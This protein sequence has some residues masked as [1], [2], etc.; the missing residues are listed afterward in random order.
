MWYI[1]AKE[2]PENRGNSSRLRNWSMIRFKHLWKG[3]N[4]STRNN[5]KKVKEIQNKSVLLFLMCTV[6]HTWRSIWFQ[7]F[8]FYRV[9]KYFSCRHTNRNYYALRGY[10]K[11]GISQTISHW[12]YDSK[13]ITGRNSYIPS[14]YHHAWHIM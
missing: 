4:E 13:P 1:D 11:L 6:K 2:L 3:Q 14:T 10:N 5:K 8:K 7:L 12:Y 9:R